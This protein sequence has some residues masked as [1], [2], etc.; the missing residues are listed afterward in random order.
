MYVLYFYYLS[1]DLILFFSLTQA[2]KINDT[3]VFFIAY[4]NL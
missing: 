4:S 2:K 1:Q 3:V